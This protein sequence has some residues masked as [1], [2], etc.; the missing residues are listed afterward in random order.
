M[1]LILDHAVEQ[2]RQV[3]LASTD[4]PQKSE[5][6]STLATSK[7]AEPRISMLTFPCLLPWHFVLTVCR[8]SKSNDPALVRSSLRPWSFA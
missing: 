5:S 7:V 3:S 8:T 4:P 1:V 6:V 2:M